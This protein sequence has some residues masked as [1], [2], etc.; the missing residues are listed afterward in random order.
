MQKIKKFTFRFFRIICCLLTIVFCQSVKAQDTISIADFGLKPDTRENAVPYLQKILKVCKDKTNPV[1]VFPQGRYDFWPQHCIEREYFES[2]T[3]DTNPRRLAILIEQFDGLTFDGSGSDFIF[4]DRMQPFTIDN[5]RNITIRNLNVDWDIPLTAQATVEAVTDDYIDLSINA[6]E[7]PYI[8]ENGKLVF[9]GEGWKSKWW[10][11]MEFDKTTRIVVPCS[12][13]VTLGNNWGAYRAEELEK[14]KV[15]LHY[16]FTRKPAVGNLLVLRHSERDHAGI[17]IVDSKDI[18]LENLNLYHYPGLGV[19][20]QY[21]E[22]LT[23]KHVNCIPNE[24]KERILSGH[25]DGFQVSNCKGDVVIDNCMFHALMDDPINVHGTSVRV[26]ERMDA[27]TLRCKFMHPQSVGMTWA[28]SGDTVGFIE[29]KSM[30]TRSI[31]IVK[32]FKKIDKVFFEVSFEQ[33]IPKDISP[34]YALENQTWTCNVSITN[35]YFKSCRARGILLST[36]GKVVIER[37]IFESSG[38]AIL[39]CGDA[40]YWYESGPV[41]NVLITKNIFRAPCMTSMYQFCEGVITIFPVIPEKIAQTPAFHRNIIVTDNE[42]H[43]YDYPILYALSVENLE[44]SNNKL[45]RSYDYEPFHY[46]KDGLTFE[47]CKK[48]RVHGNTAEGDVLGNTIQLIHTPK[49]EFKLGKDSFFKEL[50]IKN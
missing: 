17:F 30:E 20:S 37:N 6:Y 18:Q 33:A 28:C 3:D 35:S 39:L 21:S 27:F 11:T 10:A 47:L 2:N 42:F 36:S 34:E 38:T 29:S 25:D 14:G 1:L 7:S 19:L 4:H 43:L 46:R 41:K 5:C 23:Y 44:F 9:V 16:N 31:G 12:G 13:D 49:K 15:R 48:V 26:I 8:I 40:N 24:K 22:N 50:K 45:I 32:S